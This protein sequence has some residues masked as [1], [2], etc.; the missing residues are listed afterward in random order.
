MRR[1]IFIFNPETDYALAVGKD[2]YNPP[3]RIVKLRK[4]MQLTPVFL[5]SPQ[6]II[7]VED[8]FSTFLYPDKRLVKMLKDRNIGTLHLS[9][10][11]SFLN[12]HSFD[13]WII[14][15]WGWNHSLR[16]QLLDSGMNENLLKTE[17]EIDTLRLLS[18]RRTT[19]PFQR[20]LQESLPEMNIK[21]AREFFNVE[22]AMKFAAENGKVFFKAPWSSS[23]RGII[24]W[25][26]NDKIRS[27]HKDNFQIM[28]ELKLKEWLGGFI[29]KQGSV[30][31]EIAFNRIADFATEWYITNGE[32]YYIGLSLFQTT[33]GG[34][35]LSNLQIPQKEIDNSLCNISPL[36]NKNIIEAQ[37][38]AIKD[39]ITEGYSGPVGIDML[40][41][42][43]GT[44]DPCVEINLRY[45]MG[46][47]SIPDFSLKLNSIL[48][49]ILSRKR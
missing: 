47:I 44:I 22:E 15:P 9:E 18:H 14:S 34:R 30:M 23:G 26:T 19:I 3:A 37:Y 10:L 6:D 33:K 41:A 5:A 42:S 49:P 43:D 7:L 27:A 13:E 4:T 46:M 16:R 48:K 28:S 2:H 24:S 40:I 32:V 39:T 8:D 21:V 11:A 36:W 12:D 38:K 29:K 25:D 17:K 1:R 45:T 31:G 20:N 35:Y